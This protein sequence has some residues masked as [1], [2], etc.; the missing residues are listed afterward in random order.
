MSRPTHPQ[1]HSP[2]PLCNIKGSQHPP[3]ARPHNRHLRGPAPRQPLPRTRRRERRAPQS[4]PRAPDPLPAQIGAA[5][6]A[7]CFEGGCQGGTGGAWQ[8]HQASGQGAAD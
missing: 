4:L 2:N 1:K 8:D 3:Q 5:Q 6:D 7:G